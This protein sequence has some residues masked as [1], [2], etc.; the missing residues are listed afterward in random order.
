MS[1]PIWNKFLTERDKQVFAA[2]GYGT[3]QGFGKRPALLVVDVNYNFC[4]DRPEPILESIKRWR[5]SCGED[6]WAGIREIKKLLA[7]ARN[8][9]LPVIY[10]TGTGREDNWDRGAWAWKSSRTAERPRTSGTNLDGNTI[11]A[12]I[13]PQPQDIVIEKQKP[14]VFYGTPL[15]SYLVLLGVDS[16]LM[17]G[18]TTSGCVR[19]SVIDA[20]SS[21][22]RVSVVEEGCFDRSQASHA[23]NLCDMNAKYADIVKL[24]ETLAFIETLP[25]GLFELP[26]GTA[27]ASLRA[28]R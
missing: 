1:E 15:Q 19:A 26:K 7:A 18:T 9:G 20:F 12:E 22:Y 5:N 27:T 25:Q 11:V 2:S 16:L 10:S 28:V 21:N 24:D 23:L 6:A 14:S 8:K 13:A 4:G 17:V 3:R